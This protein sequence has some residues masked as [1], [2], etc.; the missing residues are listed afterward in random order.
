MTFSRWGKQGLQVLFGDLAKGTTVDI[1]AM[2]REKWEMGDDKRT[3]NWSIR[4]RVALIR[5]G[6]AAPR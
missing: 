6:A 3:Y 1:Q 4:H 2:G 5:D